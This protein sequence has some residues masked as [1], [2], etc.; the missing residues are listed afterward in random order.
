MIFL[1]NLRLN[2]NDLHTNSRLEQNTYSFE[3]IVP[4]NINY[5]YEVLQ[6]N[7]ATL[8]AVYP[9]LQT[10]IIGKS[11]LGKDIVAIKL[12][13]GQK[14]VF[15]SAAFHANEWITAPLLMKFIEDFCISYINGS[16][17]YG[18]NAENIF[19]NVSIYIVPMV[20]PDGV[21]LVT[22]AIQENSIVYNNAKQIA[23]NFPSIPFP[24]R[25]ESKY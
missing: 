10:E 25:L 11:V 13:T 18:Y 24:N 22:G 1:E 5:S 3:K 15:Y 20:N 9:F 8:K 14:E 16:N 17:I 2:P 21:D 4:T 12:G 19:N 7:I 6:N 23:E